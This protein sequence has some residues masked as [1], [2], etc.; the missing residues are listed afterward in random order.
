M[1]SM[2]PTPLARSGGGDAHGQGLE[3]PDKGAGGAKGLARQLNSFDAVEQRAREAGATAD[4]LADA[5]D[6]DLGF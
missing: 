6:V 5:F 1:W 4:G 2:S 3:P